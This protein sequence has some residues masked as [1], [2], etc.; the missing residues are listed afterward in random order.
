MEAMQ[1][2]RIW[3]ECSVNM[4]G[5]PIVLILFCWAAT[6]IICTG[7]CTVAAYKCEY[8]VHVDQIILDYFKNI[9]AGN[10][11]LSEEERANELARPPKK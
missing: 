3:L 11:R 9:T 4:L 8:G 2:F 1:K 7:T 10:D 6:F 5:Y